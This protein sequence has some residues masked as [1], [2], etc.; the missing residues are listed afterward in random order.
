MRQLLTARMKKCPPKEQLSTGRFWM[1]GQPAWFDLVACH[2][3][4]TLAPT[5]PQ[6]Q[7][8]PC[9][10]CQVPLQPPIPLCVPTPC[11]AGDIRLPAGSRERMGSA[12]KSPRFPLFPLP[13]QLLLQSA[14][15][16]SGICHGKQ[17]AG[18]KF[19]N[20]RTLKDIRVTSMQGLGCRRFPPSPS[21]LVAS[22]SSAPGQGLGVSLCKATSPWP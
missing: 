18:N 22:P 1:G 19:P 13:R 20:C 14:G 7:V 2:P 9:P 4:E 17:R 11:G 3:A 16:G 5:S 15:W 8:P 12:I 10:Q 6:S 21:K